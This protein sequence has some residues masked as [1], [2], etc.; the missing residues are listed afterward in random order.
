MLTWCCA[1]TALESKVTAARKKMAEV[2]SRSEYFERYEKNLHH[3][4]DD[5][6]E[7]VQKLEAIANIWLY[8]RIYSRY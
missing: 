4:K 7:L 2:S 6:T 5:I 1:F 8:V 3:T